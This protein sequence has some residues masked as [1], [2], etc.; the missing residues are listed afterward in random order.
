MRNAVW[1]LLLF[2]AAAAAALFLG[3]NRATVTLFWHPYRVDMS[4]NFVLLILLLLFA[5]VLLALRTFASLRKI[6]L[7]AG[8]WRQQQ[9]ERTM[10]QSL[11]NAMQHFTH[12]HPDKATA[13]AEQAIA[14]AR[15]IQDSTEATD[16]RDSSAETL[17]ESVI[18]MAEWILAQSKADGAKT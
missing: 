16:S 2:A 6:Q 9:R 17:T 10:H 12:G 3:D 11:L 1:F 8:I 18:E 13:Q 5:L 7:H 15:Q 4:L 14:K